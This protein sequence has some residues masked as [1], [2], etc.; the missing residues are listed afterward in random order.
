MLI[1]VQQLN[2]H[3]SHIFGLQLLLLSSQVVV[4]LCQQLDRVLHAQA[5]LLIHLSLSLG[6]IVQLFAG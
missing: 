6:D 3:Q 1:D 4:L 5:E 2:A